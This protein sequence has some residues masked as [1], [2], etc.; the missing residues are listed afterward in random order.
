MEYCCPVCGKKQVPSEDVV[1]DHQYLTGKYQRVRISCTA[2]EHESAIR[3]Y[4]KR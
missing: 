2:C 1:V 4:S 3:V